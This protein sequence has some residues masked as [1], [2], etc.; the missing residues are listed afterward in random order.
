MA[1]RD[2]RHERLIVA[3]MAIS[4]LIVT[5]DLSV[6]SVALPS[7]GRDLRVPAAVLSWVVVAASLANAG[8]LVIGGKLVDRLGHRR[9]L[10]TGLS[11][12]VLASLVAAFSSSLAPLLAARAAQGVATALIAPASFSLITAFLPEGPVRHRALGVFGVTQGLSLILGLFLGGW[13]VTRFGWHA[14]F[15]LN[16]PVALVSLV[17]ALRV[18]PRPAHRGR[19]PIDGAGALVA[20]LAMVATVSGISA[21]GEVGLLATRTMLLLGGAILLFGLLV[22]IERRMPAPMLPPALFRR[23][24]FA[25]SAAASLFVLGGVGGL[26]VLSQL[27]MQHVLGMSAAQ[28][29]LGMLPYAL[30]VMATG[31]G[32]PLLLGRFPPRTIVLGACLVNLAGF[33]LLA[34]T[35][36]REYG[37]SIAPGV[38]LCP[39]GSVSAFIALMQSGTGGL[40]AEEQGVGTAALFVCHQV[41]VAAGASIAMS[42][43]GAHEAAVGPAGLQLAFAALAV[44]V[45]IAFLIALTGLRSP[46][47]AL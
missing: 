23:P 17:L 41:G 27:A 35:V 14:A 26:F 10:A 9:V 24:G 34:A 44:G 33:A 39:L 15:L 13:V 19:E 36:G 42:L 5:A 4:Y 3:L 40:A 22:L 31:Q 11:I 20:V 30:A 46:P 47:R 21:A 37:L 29:G 43:A 12:Y 18:L 32:A 6:A 8:L 28:S 45:G 25:V 2:V 7:I 38:I 1:D 16:L